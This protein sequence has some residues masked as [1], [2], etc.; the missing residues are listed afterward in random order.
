ILEPIGETFT[1]YNSIDIIV[2]PGVAFDDNM[3]RLGRGKAY[4]DKLLHNCK[5]KK[6]GICFNF[7]IINKVPVD[8]H[9]IT[10]DLVISDKI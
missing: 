6:I 3:N 2:V 4:Y 9:D 1:D 10:M 7:Q 8:K 5:A